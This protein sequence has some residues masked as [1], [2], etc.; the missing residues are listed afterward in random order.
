MMQK[1][2]VYSLLLIS[3]IVVFA[4]SLSLAADQVTI[5]S[6]SGLP[7]CADQSVNV[8]L[9][10]DSEAKALEIVLEI[11]SGGVG[12]FLTVTGVDWDDAFEAAMTDFVVVMDGVDGVSP[13]TLRIAAMNLQGGGLAAGTH[14]VAALA[15]TISD[16]CTGDITISNVLEYDYG[17]PTGPITTQ[18]VDAAAQIVALAVIDGLVGVANQDPVITDVDDAT[19]PWNTFFTASA[20][21]TDADLAGGCEALEYEKVSGPDSLKVDFLTG[22]ITWQ[23]TGADVCEH[24]VEVKVTDGCDGVDVTTFTIC[25]T[26]IGPTLACPEDQTV[27]FGNTLET[28][29]VGDDADG[30][31]Y[32]L[33]YSL[34]SWSGPGTPLV[35]PGTGDITWE[36]ETLPDFTGTFTMTVGVTDSANV[37]VDC[38]PDNYAECSF[39]VT[40]LAMSVTIECQDGPLGDGVFL[41]METTVSVDML[42]SRFNN[43]PIGG[44]DFLIKYDETALSFLYADPGDFL[45]DCGWEYFQYRFGPD[46]NCSGGCPSGIVRIV[47]MAESN[48]GVDFDGCY[49]NSVNNL[50]QLAELHFLVSRDGNLECQMVPIRFMWF[51]CGD[52]TLSTPDGITLLISRDVFDFNGGIIPMGVEF[53][54][55]GGAIEECDTYDKGNPERWVDFYNGCVKII[56]DNDIDATGDLNM[57][58]IG[59]E[60]ADAVMFTQYFVVGLDAFGTHPEGSIAASDANNDGITLTVADLVYLIRVVVGDAMPY[61]KTSPVAANYYIEGNVVSVDSDMGAVAI[62]VEGNQAPN[63]IADNMEML[64]AFDGANTRIVVFSMNEGETFSG[65]FISVDDIISIE[66]ATY[67][68]NPVAAKNVPT[69]FALEQNYPNPFN[70]TAMIRFS[71][72][73]PTNWT[74]TFYNVT[75]QVVESVSGYDQGFVEYVWDASELASGIYFYKIEAGEFTA[76]KKAAL[77]K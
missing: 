50:T 77:L 61:T 56:C 75:G 20:A 62:V 66:F 38:S 14:T 19:I 17:N 34:V 6:K 55:F 58:N 2:T 47:A 15:F 45:V 71:L 32:P 39:D 13:D 3:F 70:P 7:R 40:V 36:T 31:P 12:A 57:N 18:Y 41:G 64:Y 33:V 67:E 54:T 21:A 24:A 30:G 49:D 11:S 43:I 46:G 37:C 23:T 9:E 53:P 44:F 60:I 42:D 51:D 1:R 27:F 74:L 25:V 4:A 76:T 29:V 10:N 73:N 22:A 63:L 59:Y 48:D 69:S 26:N 8:T 16:S 28:A 52:N 5:E 35:H 72:P 68:G 65:D